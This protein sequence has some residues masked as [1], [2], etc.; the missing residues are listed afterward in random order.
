MAAARRRVTRVGLVGSCY[1]SDMLSAH[2]VVVFPFVL[3]GAKHFC[4]KFGDSWPEAGREQ[5]DKLCIGKLHFHHR[6]V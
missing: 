2:V 3:H 1:V 6:F 4:E 5:F